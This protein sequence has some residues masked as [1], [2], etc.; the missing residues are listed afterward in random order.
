MGPMET[1]MLISAIT[2]AIIRVVSNVTGEDPEVL[3][4]K[5]KALEVKADDLEEWLRKGDGEDNE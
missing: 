5:I 3:K 1:A 2:D 4:L